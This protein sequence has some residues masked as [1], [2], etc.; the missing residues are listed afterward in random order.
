[1][2]GDPTTAVNSNWGAENRLGRIFDEDTDR[3]V[4]LAVDHGYFMGP[5]T[6]LE[7]PSETIE[8]LVP[9]ADAIMLTRGVLRTS[10]SPR[11]DLPTVLRISGGNSILGDQMTDEKITTSVEEAIRC[12][13]SAVAVSVYVGSEHEHQTLM[14]LADTVN[15]CEDVGIPVLAVTAV[16]KEME[17]RDARYL[18]LSCRISAELGAHFVKTYYCDGFEEVVEASP[19]PL[20]C[21]G[22]PKSD[23]VID[24]FR[25]ARGAVDAGAYGLDM[26]RNIWQDDHP[27]A[28]IQA[29]RSVVH[30]DY[31]P[32]EATQLYEK[33]V[34]KEELE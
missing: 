27:V 18:A 10:L 3:T 7:V 13:A 5:T 25:M 31:D 34:E 2:T 6:D 21:A 19:V 26:G 30:E 22:G 29:I 23:D 33:L 14:N 17:K 11:V 16:G 1:M 32:E 12:N 24:T 15:A 8:P 9:Y 4:M 20:I 28:K